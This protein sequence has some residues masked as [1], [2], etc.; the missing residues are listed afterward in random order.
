[1]PVHLGTRETHSGAA[2]HSH[3]SFCCLFYIFLQILRPIL[4]FLAEPFGQPCMSSQCGPHSE[5]TADKLNNDGYSCQCLPNFIG[6]PPNCKPECQSNDEC[7]THM[8]CHDRVCKNPCIN[9]ICSKNA[10]CTVKMHVPTCECERNY[11]GNPFIEC[12]PV[13]KF[14]RNT[15]FECTADDDCSANSTCIDHVCKNPCNGTKCGVHAE[16][17]VSNHSAICS[18]RA[19]YTGEPHRACHPLP[20]K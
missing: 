16:C 9:E 20:C 13:R 10:K 12:T 18:C 4:P 14:L 6:T 17:N 1:M 19:G 2:H 7:E 5:C 8:A 3:V 11:T 15:S